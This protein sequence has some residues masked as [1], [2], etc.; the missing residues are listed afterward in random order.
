MAL[1]EKTAE[2]LRKGYRDTV[3]GLPNGFLTGF[4]MYR[5]EHW[6]NGYDD[7][8]AGC[9]ENVSDGMGKIVHAGAASVR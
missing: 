3:S 8:P 9:R 7:L 2:W 5:W 6:W 1:L 4:A